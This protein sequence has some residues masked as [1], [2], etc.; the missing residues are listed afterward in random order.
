MHRQPLLAGGQA[1]A[2]GD[3]PALQDAVKFQPQVPV[4]PARV[5]ALERRAWWRWI[6]YAPPAGSGGGVGAGF[7]RGFATRFGAGFGSGVRS[8]SRLRAYSPSGFLRALGFAV[9][10]RAVL[11]RTVILSRNYACG[12]RAY[13][14]HVG[15][16][17]PKIHGTAHGGA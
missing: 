8:K 9:F 14:I 17:S 11:G 16:K 7:P 12:S 10:F 2:L 15:F 6:E 5:V 1:W 4:Q 3:G 13:H